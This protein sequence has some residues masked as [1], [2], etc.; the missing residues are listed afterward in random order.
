[1]AER[2][3]MTPGGAWQVVGD[4]VKNGMTNDRA[5]LRMANGW[6]PF[7]VSDGMIWLRRW[8]PNQPTTSKTE[9]GA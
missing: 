6:E 4:V 8:V 7:A 5:D 2:G 3:A 9:G 1:M